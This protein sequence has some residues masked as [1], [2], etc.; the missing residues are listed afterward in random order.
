M[1]TPRAHTLVVKAADKSGAPRVTP[2]KWELVEL[3][4]WSGGVESKFLSL[5]QLPISGTAAIFLQLADSKGSGIRTSSPCRNFC[6]SSSSTGAGQN[7]K[8]KER[9]KERKKENEGGLAGR[10]TRKLVQAAGR[11]W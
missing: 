8:P 7:R 5:T 1:H 6:R 3:R 2:L 4:D 9:E 11:V 10:Q